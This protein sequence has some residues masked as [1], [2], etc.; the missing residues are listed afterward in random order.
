MWRTI[1]HAWGVLR[2]FLLVH[3][4]PAY[5]ERQLQKRQG[6]CQRC[7][8]CCLIVCRCPFL[9]G[10]N[11]CAIYSSRSRQ[12]RKF[13]IDERDLRDVPTCAFRFETADEAAEEVESMEAGGAREEPV[14]VG[15]AD[16]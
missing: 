8:D 5:V 2:R 11:E 3:F 16:V 6:E 10:E 13:P 4:R 12:C 15:S 1:R 7:G 14:A 9:K